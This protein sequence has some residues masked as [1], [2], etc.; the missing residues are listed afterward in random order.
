[1]RE[2]GPQEI[3]FLFEQEEEVRRLGDPND[4]KF[5]EPLIVYLTLKL[6]Y[7]II[8]LLFFVGFITL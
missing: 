3:F 7:S 5:K 4:K 2:F 1:M 6:T 8:S